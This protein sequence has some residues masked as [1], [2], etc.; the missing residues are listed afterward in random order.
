MR[1]RR[2]ILPL[3]IAPAVLCATPALGAM[4]DV[5]VQGDSLSAVSRPFFR[6]VLLSV[7]A[8]DAKG[9]RTAEQGLAHLRRGPLA[10]VVVFA[11]GTNNISTT[12]SAAYAQVIDAALEWIGPTR[13]LVVADI[14]ARRPIAHLNRVLAARA[15]TLPPERFQVARW[16]AASRSGAARLA[17]GIHPR[18]EAGWRVRA[19][20][21]AD[22]AQRCASA[23]SERRLSSGQPQPPA[24]KS[25]FARE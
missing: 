3:V 22:A 6:P 19:G 11:H 8:Y 21:I 16:V 24:P 13:C 23:Q 10:E 17:D 15:R 25:A 14:Y 18:D 12:S 20:V 5:V 9:S 7:R 1:A 2:V 4:A